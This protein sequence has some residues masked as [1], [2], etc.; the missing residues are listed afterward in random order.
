MCTFPGNWYAVNPILSLL[1]TDISPD[2]GSPDIIPLHISR[3]V[4]CDLS[5]LTANELMRWGLMN[6][7]KDGHEGG[8]AI[9]HSHKPVSDFPA[10][11]DDSHCP[12]DQHNFFEKAFPCLYPYGQGRIEGARPIPLGFP[13]HIHWSL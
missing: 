6:M 1:V 9:C 5:N 4:D 8:Y 2:N 7:W 13:K 12:M 3:S 10:V 11:G